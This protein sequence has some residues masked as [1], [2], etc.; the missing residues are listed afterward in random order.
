MQQRSKNYYT[1]V[2]ERKKVNALLE[3][4]MSMFASSFAIWIGLRFVT[5]RNLLLMVAY[6]DHN[7]TMVTR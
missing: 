5:E 7:V 2:C 4:L 1:P 6:R 3:C